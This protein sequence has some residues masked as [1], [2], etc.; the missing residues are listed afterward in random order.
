[1]DAAHLMISGRVQGVWYRASAREA[2]LRIGVAGWVRNLPTGDVE[3]FVEG[4]RDAVNAFIDWCRQ[5]PPHARVDRV[6]VTRS[7]PGRH[8]AFQIR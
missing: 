7:E 6:D 8:T 2:A 1:M 3:A 4:E 5:G